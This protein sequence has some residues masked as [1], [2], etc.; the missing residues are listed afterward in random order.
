[1]LNDTRFTQDLQIT[2]PHLSMTGGLV[3]VLSSFD[4]GQANTVWKRW[5]LSIGI[6]TYSQEDVD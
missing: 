1:M 5:A 3:G 6:C 4:T 2:W